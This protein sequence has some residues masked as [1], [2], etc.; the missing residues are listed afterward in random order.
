MILLQDYYF[1]DTNDAYTFEYIMRCGITEK[2]VERHEGS[3]YY[4]SF[5]YQ[6]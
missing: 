4:I 3:H 2:N 1:I 5:Q 6:E